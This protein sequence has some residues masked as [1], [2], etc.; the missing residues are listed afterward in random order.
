MAQYAQLKQSG[1]HAGYNQNI[2][3][4]CTIAHAMSFP[5]YCTTNLPN[6]PLISSNFSP[7]PICISE[8]EGQDQRVHQDPL[9]TEQ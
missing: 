3:P 7:Q 8:V 6:I 4:S 2:L 5:V 9:W 1:L